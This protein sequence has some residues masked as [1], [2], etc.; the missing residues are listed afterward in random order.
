MA[1]WQLIE[2]ASRTMV[3][4]LENHLTVVLPGSAIDV[5]LATPHSFAE[6]KKVGKSTISVF[7]YRVTEHAEMRNNLQRRMPDGSFR[8]QPLVLEVYY[9]ITTWGARGQNPAQND[10]AAALEEHRLL[11]VVLQCLYD[12]AEVGRAEL[13]DD[14]AKPSVWGDTDSMHIML[15]SLPVEEMYRIWDSSELAYQLSAAY[16]VRVLSLESL[17][18]VRS[19]TVIDANLVV[20]RG[21]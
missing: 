21:T 9:L 18:V 7:L 3:R 6:L 14:P 8:R 1:T 13:F 12:H 10:A 20:G 2:N 4:L 11:G 17:E 19:G 5:K 15:E 16:R